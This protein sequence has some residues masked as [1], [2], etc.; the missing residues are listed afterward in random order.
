MEAQ[1]LG[2][3]R[4]DRDARRLGAGS[5]RAHP[6]ARPRHRTGTVARGPHRSRRARRMNT[7]TLDDRVGRAAVDRDDTRG[8]AAARRKTNPLLR[9][10]DTLQRRRAVLGFAVAVAKKFGEDGAGNLAALIAYYGFLSIF[11]LLLALTTVLG[12]VLRS[13]PALQRRILD[14]ALTQFPV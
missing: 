12:S 13:H 10:V 5:R 11:P 4:D 2:R 9:R 14:S 1:P 7:D 6:T 8:G 3:R